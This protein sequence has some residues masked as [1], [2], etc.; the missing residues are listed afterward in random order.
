MDELLAAIQR[1]RNTSPGPDNIRNQM[2]HYLPSAAKTFLLQLDMDR[3]R[4]SSY[5]ERRHNIPHFEIWEETSP[6]HK[7]QAYLLN[8]LF[9]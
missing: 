6:S 3:K 4:L 7:L 9:M 8:Q 2:I 5:V 1:S